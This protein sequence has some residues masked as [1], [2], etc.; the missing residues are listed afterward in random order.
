LNSAIN[1]ELKNDKKILE[2]LIAFSSFTNFF[3]NVSNT[4]SKNINKNN[5]VVTQIVSVHIFN[6]YEPILE[7]I[8]YEG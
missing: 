7:N 2:L 8:I 4:K 5:K 1:C 6:F 3:I